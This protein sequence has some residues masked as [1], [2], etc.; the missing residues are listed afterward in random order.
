M[1]PINQVSK[2][3]AHGRQLQCFRCYS[4]A[5][6]SVNIGRGI[7]QLPALPGVYPYCISPLHKAPLNTPV[8]M[9]RQK[10]AKQNNSGDINW[11]PMHS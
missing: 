7:E 11:S 4:V 9:P 1:R 8:L 3:I 2:V 6:K 10:L 5:T